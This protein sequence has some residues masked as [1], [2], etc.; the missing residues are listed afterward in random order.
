M[1]SVVLFDLFHTLVSVPAPAA[2]GQIPA[3]DLLGVSRAEW[4]RRY[5]D[6]DE[7][8]RCVG[9]VMDH[10]EA[11]RRVAHSIDPGVSEDRIL[12]AVESRRRCFEIGLV[13]VAPD[14]LRLDAVVF[15]YL[16][17]VRKPDARIYKEALGRWASRPSSSHG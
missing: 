4:Q 12:A 10:V 11:V 2:V 14:V 9:R 16:L 5:H 1:P 8:G 13:E 3:A 17:G 6:D 7:Q 15:S